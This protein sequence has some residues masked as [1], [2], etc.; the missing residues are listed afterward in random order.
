MERFKG[1]LAK[2]CTQEQITLYTNQLIQLKLFLQDSLF[3]HGDLRPSNI[4]LSRDGI[5]DIDFDWAGSTTGKPIPRYPFSMFHKIYKDMASNFENNI[6]TAVLQ[7]VQMI[8]C[9]SSPFIEWPPGALPGSPILQDHV[10]YWIDFMIQLLADKRDNF[11]GPK[12][13]DYLDEK[14]V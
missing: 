2:E 6:G 9:S 1:K 7:T 14:V 12:S 3:V 5:K 8:R 4:L 10:V 11:P 13:K